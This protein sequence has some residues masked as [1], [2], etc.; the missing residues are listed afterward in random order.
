MSVHS[1]LASE[2]RLLQQRRDSVRRMIDDTLD[3]EQ[4]SG[5]GDLPLNVKQRAMISELAELEQRV[6]RAEG[7]LQRSGTQP[8]GT[9]H[10]LSERI[11]RNAG[12]PGRGGHR[13][14]N[15]RSMAPLNFGEKQLRRMMQAAQNGESCRIASEKREFSTADPL[16]P[17]SLFPQPVATIHESRLLD[18]LPGYGIDTPSVTF[19]RHI[20]TTG[21]PAAVAE[22]ALKPELVF[23]TDALTATAVK[24]AANNGLSWEIINDWPAFQAYAKPNFS[25]R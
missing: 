10:D 25:G 7:E 21:T 20:S 3:Y 5:R 16:L 9:L 22:G 19:I 1:A 11:R 18:R 2:V 23:N 8:G 13:R 24:L 17:A 4:R 14:T 15:R 12:Q 6:Q